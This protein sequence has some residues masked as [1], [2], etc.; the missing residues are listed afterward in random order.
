MNQELELSVNIKVDLAALKE[1]FLDLEEFSRILAERVIEEAKRRTP[2][3]T[4][5]LRN[6]GHVRSADKS[7]FL[8]GFGGPAAPYAVYVHENLKARHRVGEAKFLEK[9]MAMAEKFGKEILR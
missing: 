6:S 2:V 4:G 5:T 9:A 8:V 3:R 1:H 7:G